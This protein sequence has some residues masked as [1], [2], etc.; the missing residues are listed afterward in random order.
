[1]C[2][3]CLPTAGGPMLT[4]DKQTQKREKRDLILY[5]GP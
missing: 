1:M 2:V 5:Y 4:T 3:K